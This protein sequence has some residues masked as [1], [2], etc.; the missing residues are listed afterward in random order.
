MCPLILS[1]LLLE[2]VAGRVVVVLGA[3]GVLVVVVIVVGV[4]VVE[5]VELSVEIV[6]E[7]SC[8][9]GADVI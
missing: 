4:I 8:V 5:E 6:V 7:T 2:V 9:V 3:T 1:T